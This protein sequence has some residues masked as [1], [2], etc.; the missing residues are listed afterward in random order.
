[1]CAVSREEVLI[2]KNYC[3]KIIENPRPIDAQP[4]IRDGGYLFCDDWWIIEVL[5]YFFNGPEMYMADPPPK[6]LR[7][8]PLWSKEAIVKEAENLRPVGAQGI[9]EYFTK[10]REMKYDGTLGVAGN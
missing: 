10:R 3:Q 5:K 1:M 9:V 2:Y 4:H 7:N 8:N 6:R